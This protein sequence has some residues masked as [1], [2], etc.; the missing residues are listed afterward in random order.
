MLQF[1]RLLKEGA[2]QSFKVSAG[3]TRQVYAFA[4][5]LMLSGAHQDI[6]I[7]FLRS[8]QQDSKSGAGLFE[9]DWITD[10]ELTDKTV[11]EIE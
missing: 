2:V 1:E 9:A 8:T 4:N 10:L 3:S 7:N 5:A 6:T 11:V